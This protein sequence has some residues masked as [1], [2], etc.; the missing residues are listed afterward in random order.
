MGE[1]EQDDMIM[2]ENKEENISNLSTV[3]IK[4]HQTKKHKN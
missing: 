2:E 1:E 4:A 3:Q